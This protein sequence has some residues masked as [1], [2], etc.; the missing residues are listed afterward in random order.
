MKT[1]HSW[2]KHC[3]WGCRQCSSCDCQEAIMCCCQA[4]YFFVELLETKIRTCTGSLD[5]LVTWG[6]EWLCFAVTKG[7]R[8]VSVCQWAFKSVHKLCNALQWSSRTH[9]C[10][11]SVNQKMQTN[12]NISQVML[13]ILF[14]IVELNHMSSCL[15]SDAGFC[16]LN[17]RKFS[18]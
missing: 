17:W 16:S 2:P 8:N 3:W 6:T 18:W 15:A 7:Y 1:S 12:G 4:L 13:Q 9:W 11:Q 14:R 5:I 10:L